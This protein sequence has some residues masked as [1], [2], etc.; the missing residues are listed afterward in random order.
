ML[1]KLNSVLDKKANERNKR[2]TSSLQSLA[3][4]ETAFVLDR[5]NSI[6]VTEEEELINS[7]VAEETEKVPA[8]SLRRYKRPLDLK[9]TYIHSLEIL[10]FL[11]L[12]VRQKLYV[13]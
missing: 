11:K 8:N 3:D 4:I 12:K 2:L 9:V 10:R 1:K 5:L 7:S 6:Q 13:I